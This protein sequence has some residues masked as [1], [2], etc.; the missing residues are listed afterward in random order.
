MATSRRRQYVFAAAATILAFVL[1]ELLL[2]VVVNLSVDYLSRRED[3][4]FEYRLWQMH[5]FNNFMGMQEPDGDLFWKLRA[6]YRDGFI[7]TNSEGFSGTEIDDRQPNEFRILFL[8]DSTPLG[9]GLERSELS[10][11]RQLE[12]GLRKEVPGRR[13][14][15]INAAVA[16]Y[17][18]W[19]C[20]KQLELFGD[21][22]Q[23]DL[24]ITY[25]GNNDPSINGYLSD[26]Q[27]YEQT[28]YFG[29]VN[30]LL[31]HSYLY[32]ALKTVVL[33]LRT[34]G[35]S[36]RQLVPRVSVA[37]NAD[38]LA[39]IAAWCR[40]HQTELMI[41]T[42]PTPSLWP[43]GIQFKI[44]SRGKDS[45]E[46]LVMADEMQANLESQWA[47]CLDT[48]LLPGLSDQWTRRVYNLGYQDRGSLPELI[49]Q[50]QARLQAM[51]DDARLWNNLG[52]LRWRNREPAADDFRRA[53]AL[54]PLQPSP[55][56][57]L[58]IALLNTDSSAASLA[59]AE[60]QEL[61]NY[62]LRIKA[63][64]NANYRQF[65]RNNSIAVIDLET[66]LA[67][68]SEREYFVDHCHP[69]LRGHELIARRLVD[70]I[71]ARID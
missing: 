71:R 69:T 23:P 30:R 45:E 9:L 2:R 32:Q 59:L 58:G 62:S 53:I 65:G 60:A 52:V 15:V 1:V 8:G 48:T 51:P 25:F 12:T 46:R 27:L 5:L 20:R 66:A 4:N 11:V 63:D 3:V 56:Y 16:G 44:F 61:D 36:N 28:R 26:R 50:H 43:P 41:C 29:W 18:S 34:T 21:E 40:R 31:A 70:T 55:R 38:N 17:T 49:A 13:I 19:Q 57:N 6:S 47:L 68:L 10:F 24:V 7:S 64:Y 39:A 42:V 67:G 54:D 14:T 22:L 35:A 33:K 37:E